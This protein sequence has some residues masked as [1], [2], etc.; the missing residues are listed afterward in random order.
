LE[1]HMAAQLVREK[2]D[3]IGGLEEKQEHREIR[4]RTIAF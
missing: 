3:G 4:R 2:K 1:N